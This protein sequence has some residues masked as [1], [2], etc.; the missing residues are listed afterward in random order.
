MTAN[1][2]ATK[3][4]RH[5]LE[6]RNFKIVTNHKPLIYAFKQCSDKASPRQ[7]RQLSFIAQF[8]TELEYIAGSN[9]VI[10]DSLSRIEALRLPVEFELVD[11]AAWQK[12]D[13]ELKHLLASNSSI[14]KQSSSANYQ[15][16][17]FAPIF[18][19]LLENKFST[20]FITP[21]TLMR[22]LLTA[23]S[24]NDIFGLTF[25]AMLRNGQRAASTVNN[26][27]FPGMSNSS[28]RISLLQTGVLNMFTW[29]SSARCRSVTDLNIV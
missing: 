11:L 18:R 3:F 25:T 8:T 4:F 23:S 1:Y 26:L 17:L 29:I 2:E 6:G 21:R 7:L 22:R 12:E 15:G 16:N 10:A 20:Y 24:D 5:F 13:E 14:L 9:N 28:P 19:N 27:K